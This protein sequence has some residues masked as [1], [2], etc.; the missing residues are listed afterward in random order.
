MEGE[1]GLSDVA[2]HSLAFDRRRFPSA[3]GPHAEPQQ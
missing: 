3:T 2:I 1:S